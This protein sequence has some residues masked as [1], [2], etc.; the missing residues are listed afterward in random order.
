MSRR[1]DREGDAA[2][3]AL[4]RITRIRSELAADP[5][6]EERV[7]AVRRFQSVRLHAAYADLAK[8]PR[9]RAA[10]E[11]FLSDLYCVDDPLERDQQLATAWPR[12]RRWLPAHAVDVLTRALELHLLT[13][14]LDLLLARQ[15]KSA[16]LDETCY[17]S[18]Y[19]AAGEVAKRRRQLKLILEIG[20]ELDELASHP[21]IGV[22]LRVAHRP[23]HAA[24][25]GELQDFIERGYGAFRAMHGA[26]EFLDIVAR[27]ERAQMTR[28]LSGG[29]Q[30]KG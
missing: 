22:L 1:A 2:A 16:V 7:A 4:R 29:R 20:A 6:L 17:C 21:M 28:L 11:F 14:E 18:A 8:Q 13:M 30:P 27:R 3:G 24:G 25:L 10:A 15:L 5:R 26:G 19:L 9:Y 12:L 23:A